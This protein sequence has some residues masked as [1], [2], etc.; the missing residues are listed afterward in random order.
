MLLTNTSKENA[1]NV[2][3]KRCQS[4]EK[5][6]QEAKRGYDIA[7]SHGIVE[8]DPEKHTTIEAMLADGDSHMYALKNSKG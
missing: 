4:L 7:F 5:Y 8:F 6:N 1:E 3:S 2:V